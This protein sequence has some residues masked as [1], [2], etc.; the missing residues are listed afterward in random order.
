MDRKS[1]NRSH[2]WMEKRNKNMANDANDP[3][4]IKTKNGIHYIY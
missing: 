4:K 3:K 2:E 1:E